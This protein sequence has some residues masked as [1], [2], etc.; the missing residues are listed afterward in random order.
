MTSPISAASDGYLCGGSQPVA[1]ATN[2]YI[3][4]VSGYLDIGICGGTWTILERIARFSPLGRSI[5]WEID[6]RDFIWATDFR[7][8]EFT[9]NKYSPASFATT[10]CKPYMFALDSR[11]SIFDLPGERSTS[12][13]LCDERSVAWTAEKRDT[14]FTPV[15]RPK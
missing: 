6:N 12:F 4:L 14:G 8:V 13:K 15:K 7:G 2:G 3:C 11:P 9:T 10:I 5:A 1:V